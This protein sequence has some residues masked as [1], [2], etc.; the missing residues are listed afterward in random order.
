[1]NKKRH[2]AFHKKTYSYHF[3]YLFSDGD[4]QGTATMTVHH[5]G[6]IKNSI[7][8]KN[9]QQF[10]ASDRGYND[11]IILNWIQFEESSKQIV[12]DQSK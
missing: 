7:D 1:M 11:I 10:I 12:D 5:K 8:L 9:V 6:L 3:V 2:T 4:D